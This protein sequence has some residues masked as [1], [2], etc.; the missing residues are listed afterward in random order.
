MPLAQISLTRSLHSFLLST[1][2]SRSSVLHSVSVQSCCRWVL[3]GCSTLACPWEEVYRSTSLISSILLLQQCP[4]C[5]ARLIWMVFMMGGWYPH[6]CCFV[7]CC[8]QY[9][10]NTAQSILVQL[11]SSFL[12]ICLVS[13]HVVHPYSNIDMNAARKKLCFILSERSDFHMTDSLSIAVQ[14]FTSHVLISFSVDQTL[15]PR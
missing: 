12:S 4:A 5:L 13:I 11:L 7:G 9:L 2:L 6:S 14:A 1:G 10:F 3:A 8:L 15:L